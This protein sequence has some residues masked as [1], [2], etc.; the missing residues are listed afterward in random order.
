LGFGV[1]FE[2]TE[3]VSHN[4]LGPCQQ[5]ERYY[6]R[7]STSHD[8]GASLPPRRAASITLDSDIRLDQCTRQRAGDPDEGEERL[9]DP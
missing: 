2:E 3:E 7:K 6:G 1:D 8:E 5:N 9:A 4:L